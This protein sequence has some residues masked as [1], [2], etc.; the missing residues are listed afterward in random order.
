M[1][2][3]VGGKMVRHT[4]ADKMVWR[5]GI[6]RLQGV[7]EKTF[8]SDGRIKLNLNDTMTVSGSELDPS[9]LENIQTQPQEMNRHEL[10]EF[11]ERLKTA[12]SI[13]LKWEVERLSKVALPVAA[14]IIVLFGAPMAAIRRRGGTALGFGLSLF[15]CFIYFAFIEIGKT[16]G[17][18]GTLPPLVAVWI[19]NGFFGLQGLVSLLRG[20]N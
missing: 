10:K 11:I 16:M 18:N 19:G 8:L 7:A 2:D 12:G 14:V 1:I 3:V 13:T 6:W 5:S 4:K 15:V 20:K 9:E 17:N